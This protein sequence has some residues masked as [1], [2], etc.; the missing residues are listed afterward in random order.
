MTASIRSAEPPQRLV[1]HRLPVALLQPLLDCSQLDLPSP[2][3]ADLIL[4]FGQARHLLRPSTL[5]QRL[6]QSRSD[7]LAARHLVL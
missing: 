4:V 7:G 3:L 6:V 2:Q 5:R 1:A